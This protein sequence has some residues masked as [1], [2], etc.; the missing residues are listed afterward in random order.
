VLI[1]VPTLVLCTKYWSA[2]YGTNAAGHAHALDQAIV[3]AITRNGHGDD[4]IDR[5]YELTR[6]RPRRPEAKE[7]A[8]ALKRRMGEV[9]RCVPSLKLDVAR[10]ATIG[11]GDTFVGGFLAALA[12][13]KAASST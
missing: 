11:L 6:S 12:Q 4:Y 3:T 9:V 13:R 7:F 1:P 5:Q 2:A 10:P 8:T